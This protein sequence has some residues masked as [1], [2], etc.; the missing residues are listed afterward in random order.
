[1]KKMYLA[2]IA[3]IGLMAS[4]CAEKDSVT[5]EISNDSDMDFHGKMVELPLSQLESKLPEAKSFIVK[6]SEGNEIPSQLTYDSLLIFQANVNSG[7]TAS[8]S[9]SPCDSVKQYEQLVAGRIYPERA[10]DVAWENEIVGFRVY[11]PGTQ[12]KGERAYGYDL[13]FKYPD[14]GLVLEKLYEPETSPATW[15][16]VDSLRAID[17]ALAEEFI[18]SFSYH[19][20]H[21]MGMDCFPCGPTLGAGVAVPLVGD[22]LSFS[23][24][25]KNA[26]VLDNGPLRFTVKMDFEPRTVGDNTNVVEHRTISL[27]AGSRFN[28]TTVNYENLRNPMTVA[29][30]FPLRDEM[31]YYDKP[32]SLNLIAYSHPVQREEYG[33]ALLGV[34]VPECYGKAEKKQGHLVMV[35]D[36]QP[37]ESHKYYWGF[38]WQKNPEQNIDSWVEEV[39]SEIRGKRQDLKITIR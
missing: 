33:R 4:G 12:K 20:D 28:K 10:D 5:V 1:M 36:L 30:G 6:D 26:E 15:V 17:S 7:E 2:V 14:K 16:K 3:C 8:F 39:Q 18:E 21:G 37:G 11:G 34:A 24:C 9:I 19:V 25:Y 38:K 32:D 23:W 22:S 35:R 13:F 31:P 27:D 29:T